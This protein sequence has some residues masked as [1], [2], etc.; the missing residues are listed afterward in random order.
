MGNLS[1][2]ERKKLISLLGMMGSAH[3]GEV[4]NA[5][6]AAEKFLAARGLTWKDVITTEAPASKLSVDDIM[7]YAQTFK[8]KSDYTELCKTK[9]AVASKELLTQHKS[10]LNPDETKFL[11]DMLSIRYPTDKQINWLRKIYAKC[12][13][14]ST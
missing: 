12:K 1:Q 10:R 8:K 13:R 14:E 2:V 5:A 6:R 11:K 4:V 7:S 9:P 3:D